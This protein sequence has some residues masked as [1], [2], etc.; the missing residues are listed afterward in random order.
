MSR[1]FD[2]MS[3][4]SRLFHEEDRSVNIVDITT[5]EPFFTEHGCSELHALLSKMFD[6]FGNNVCTT[7]RPFFMKASGFPL[8]TQ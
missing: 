6:C 4:R 7:A 8:T 2:V 3:F 1:R 5:G